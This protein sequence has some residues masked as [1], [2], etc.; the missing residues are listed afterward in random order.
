MRKTING[1]VISERKLL[2]VRKGNWWI[3]PGGKPEEGES[4]EKCLRREFSEE[5]SGTEVGL[6][7]NYGAFE[8]ITPHSKT[9]M[10]AEVYFVDL[11]SELGE[12]SAEISETAWI[13]RENRDSYTLSDITS[14]VV[15]FL[16]YDSWI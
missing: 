13:S 12:P 6:R 1:L 5:I 4:D 3:L 10:K 11:E 9:Q 16:I 15:D 14:K 2:I 8:G 7:R